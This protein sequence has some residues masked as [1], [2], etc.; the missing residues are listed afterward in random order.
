[1]PMLFS[2]ATSLMPQTCIFS[3]FYMLSSVLDHHWPLLHGA[4]HC[5]WKK[6]YSKFPW[7]KLCEV[8]T[9]LWE[10]FSSVGIWNLLH[11]LPS[12]FHC[13]GDFAFCF[14]KIVHSGL[15]CITSISLHGTAF[16][17]S[18][19]CFESLF[20]VSLVIF[21]FTCGI[22]WFPKLTLLL[23]SVPPLYG[24]TMFPSHY[25]RHAFVSSSLHSMRTQGTVFRTVFRFLPP[26]N[27]GELH[28]Q[29]W[30]VFF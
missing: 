19:N 20:P 8:L 11:T 27:L 2:G 25:L 17:Y 21:F 26:E 9:A 7:L 16:L 28:I 1:M 18:L 14:T 10:L 24:L 5:F 3:P 30:S 22:F 4:S 12:S 29:V 6:I 13:R 15:G 23:V